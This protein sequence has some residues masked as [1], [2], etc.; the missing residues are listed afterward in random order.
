M[1][2]DKALKSL[3]FD[4]Q[5]LSEQLKESQSRVDERERRLKREIMPF[6]YNRC[7]REEWTVDSW[8]KKFGQ[9]SWEGDRD[10]DVRKASQIEVWKDKTID[11]EYKGEV[12]WPWDCHHYPK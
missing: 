7:L 3:A 6:R 4:K 9:V 1:P 12:W 2:D 10:A 5:K 11:T 8:E